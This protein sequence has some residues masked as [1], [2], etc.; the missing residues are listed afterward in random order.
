MVI[1]FSGLK[2]QIREAKLEIKNIEQHLD[3]AATRYND[4]P[5]E[6]NYR[7]MAI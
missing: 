6:R 4:Y 1:A 2:A 3:I 5:S 7:I